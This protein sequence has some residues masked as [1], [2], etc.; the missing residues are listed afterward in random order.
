VPD[1]PNVNSSL[2]E[3][4]DLLGQPSVTV[5]P[6]AVLDGAR[7]IEFTFDGGRFSYW[8]SPNDY[9][10]LQ[11]AD[12]RDLLPDGKGGGGGCF[13]SGCLRRGPPDGPDDV[14]GRLARLS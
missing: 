3:V 1:D 9:Q 10:P 11:S 12:R 13:T 2:A 6:N 5:N 14:H 4:H 7:T 8:V